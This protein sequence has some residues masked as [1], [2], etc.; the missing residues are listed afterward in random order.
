MGRIQGQKQKKVWV[1]VKVIR[2]L[3]ILKTVVRFLVSFSLNKSG[4]IF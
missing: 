1:E 2:E 3:L 4:D